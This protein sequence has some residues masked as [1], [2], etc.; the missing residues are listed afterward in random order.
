[1]RTKPY[2]EREYISG[3]GIYA[4][5]PFDGLDN[6]KMGVFKIGMSGN[7]DNRIRNYH[8][9]LP[10]GVYYKCFLKNPSRK[11]EGQNIQNYYVRI[12][13]EIFSNIVLNGGKVINMNIRRKNQGDT[14]WI[15]AS[16]KM[17][18]DAFDDAYIKYG[19][20]NTDLEIGELSQL[21]RIQI[22][23]ERNKIFK[24]EIYFTD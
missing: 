2:L 4:F 18:E 16:E 10:G 11:K 19:G 22:Q 14:E 13:K 23:L 24:G 3:S 5:F 21:K 6:K 9:Y 7:F 20:K 1:M 15:Y 12:E 17:I 8:T